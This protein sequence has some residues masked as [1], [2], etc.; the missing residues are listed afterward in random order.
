MS[1]PFTRR[2]L[3]ARTAML[4]A[5]AAAGPLL[6]PLRA[7]AARD[8]FW[9]MD[10][11]AQA[12]LVRRGEVSALELVDAAIARIE[13]LDPAINAVVAPLF[14]R[15]RDMA[16]G[17]LPDGPFRGVPYLVK[18]LND[19]AGAPTS[20]GSRLFAS[21]VPQQTTPYIERALAAG[22]I[23]LGKSNTPEFGLLGT[24]ESLQLG[25][26]RNPW[27]TAF[28][29]G[30]SSGGAGAA[31]AAG[32]VPFAHATDGG[33]SIRIPAACCGLFGLKPSRGRLAPAEVGGGDISVHHCV[34]RSVRDSATM[35]AAAEYRGDDALLPAVGLVTGPGQKRLRIA[36]ST[37]SYTGAAP[38]PDVEAAAQ[39]AAKLCADLGHEVIEAAPAIDGERYLEAF[40]TV[41]SSF[42]A[43]VLELARQQQLNPADVL[44]PWTLGLAD[45]YNGKPA[46]AM[47]R[48][49]EHFRRVQQAYDAFF[50]GYDLVL[51]PVLAAP[52]V[53][54]GEQA[55][56]VAYAT[57]YDRVLDWV[58][59]TPVHNGAGNAAMSV[60]LGTSSGGLPIGV[61]FAGP[62]GSERTLLELAFE[63]EEAAP[64]AERW[65]AM[66]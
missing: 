40:M 39:R 60:P 31:V 66:A 32:L 17:A 34:S 18:D 8:P 52:P 24:T 37:V 16:R 44:E 48:A 49:L 42:A 62:Q 23:P 21:Y 61:Q 19:L 30:G 3:L 53:P 46:G 64:W 59:Y 7:F 26:C 29:P 54:I 41:W 56:T 1:L 27:N 4:G 13:A 43:G 51:T 15:A 33:G 50:A 38:H 45:L 55:P 58:D 2:A 9:R 36:F 28:T 25:P 20:N 35:F 14:E 5:A 65:P 22:V 11:T 10:A 6:T 57:L 12:A 47:D 63:L